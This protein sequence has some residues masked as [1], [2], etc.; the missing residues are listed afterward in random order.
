LH[1]V[2]PQLDALRAEWWCET[3]SN[4]NIH[5]NIMSPVASR[6]PKLNIWYDKSEYK[7]SAEVIFEPVIPYFKWVREALVGR[8]SQAAFSIVVESRAP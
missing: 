5:N 3:L 8:P 1:P 2:H 7:A 6:T 4:D